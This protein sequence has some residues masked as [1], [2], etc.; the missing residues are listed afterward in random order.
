MNENEKK[1]ANLILSNGVDLSQKARKKTASKV[2]PIL[3]SAVE[4][5]HEIIRAKMR[6]DGFSEEEIEEAIKNDWF[7]KEIEENEKKF[8]LDPND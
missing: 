1:I 2:L 6:E 3:R 7:M 4:E 8:D 5:Q